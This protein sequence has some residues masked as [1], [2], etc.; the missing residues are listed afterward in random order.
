[1]SQLVCTLEIPAAH[2]KAGSIVVAGGRA[3]YLGDKSGHLCGYD[4]W[5]YVAYGDDGSEAARGTMNIRPD[6]K[7]L[8]VAVHMD[9][10]VV[11]P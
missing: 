6:A 10:G 1:M 9:G 11:V 2:L 4:Q 7:V 8:T 3:R 5:P